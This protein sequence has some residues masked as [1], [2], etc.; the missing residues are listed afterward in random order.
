MLC[1][2]LPKGAAMGAAL[3]VSRNSVLTVAMQAR[4]PQNHASGMPS[5]ARHGCVQGKR[6]IS[7]HPSGTLLSVPASQHCGCF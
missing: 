3:L 5:I 1:H 4:H 2:L 6:V 7:N